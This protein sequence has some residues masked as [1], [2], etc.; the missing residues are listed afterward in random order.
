MEGPFGHKSD[1]GSESPPS[2]KAHL[3]I[4]SGWCRNIWFIELAIF[5]LLDSR[6][7]ILAMSWAWVADRLP[8]RLIKPLIPTSKPRQNHINAI[9]VCLSQGLIEVC[10]AIHGWFAI[11]VKELYFPELLEC[12]V[13]HCVY[14]QHQ[15]SSLCLLACL[16]W[17][18]KQENY[19]PKTRFAPFAQWIKRNISGGR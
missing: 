14:E 4:L 13:A 16:L 2:W 15:I 3:Y 7:Q 1:S 11:E 19:L 6:Y 12:F 18:E 17:R 10:C 8:G 9:Y 5:H